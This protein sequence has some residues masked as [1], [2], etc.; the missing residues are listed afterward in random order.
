VAWLQSLL[1]EPD[2]VAARPEIIAQA[3]RQRGML[4]MP[5]ADE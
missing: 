2:I 4:V 1:V 3:Q 5:V